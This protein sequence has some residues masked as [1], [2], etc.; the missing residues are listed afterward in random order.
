MFGAF[1]LMMSLLA[2]L[3][4][5]IYNWLFD[6]WDR[7]HRNFAPRGPMIRAVHALLFES[8]LLIVGTILAMWW[9]DLAF[10]PAFVLDVGLSLFFVTYAYAFNWT[11]DITFPPPHA[12]A[13][14]AEGTPPA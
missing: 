3:W 1:G 5:L 13:K 10:W 9:L 14:K 7:K 2:M 4:N 6:L 8:G 11:Y 12:R